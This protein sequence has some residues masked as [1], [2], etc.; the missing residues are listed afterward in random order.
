MKAGKRFTMGGMVF[1]LFLYAL[2]AGPVVAG[3]PTPP[4]G[5]DTG[6]GV[7]SITGNHVIPPGWKTGCDCNGEKPAV[8]STGETVARNGFVTISI[9]SGRATC[10]P[11]H[12]SV[13]GTGFHFDDV[14]GPTTATTDSDSETLQLWAD[15]T[16]C[17]SAEITVTDAC[18]ESGEISVRN[19]DHGHWVLVEDIS[20]GTLDPDPG[21]CDCTSVF[22][23]IEGGYKYQDA[24]IG[25][26]RMNRWHSNGT[27]SKY[28]CTPY[29]RDYCYCV[30]FYPKKYHVGM[31]WKKKWRWDCP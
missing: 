21:I 26:N 15:D 24:Y 6:R 22:E 10:G 31:R 19:P 23:C 5:C 30:G 12:W 9:A 1:Q 25:G 14:T 2:L 7:P 8:S 20:C 27:C 4:V 13:S 3:D 16:A 28:P 11:Y 18:N 17:G 29:D